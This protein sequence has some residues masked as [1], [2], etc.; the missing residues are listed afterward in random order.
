MSGSGAMSTGYNIP[1]A[2]T[3]AQTV[4]R[5]LDLPHSGPARKVTDVLGVRSTLKWKSNKP[6]F[7]NDIVQG[8]W[9]ATFLF[10]GLMLYLM[11]LP[12]MMA[13][14]LV[15]A[16]GW[17][18]GR[19]L[20]LNLSYMVYEWTLPLVNVTESFTWSFFNFFDSLF[21]GDLRNALEAPLGKDIS[22]AASDYK[23]LISDKFNTLQHEGIQ[24][25]P[26][27]LLSP[28]KSSAK[29]A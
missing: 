20:V 16:I 25:I 27:V 9:A 24:G 23:Y 1:G 19:S 6:K 3:V 21:N 12:W 2:T 18:H 13:L 10:G 28:S 5:P 14:R 26:K 11:E 17:D 29:A 8:L 22:N 15:D 7:T 4:S